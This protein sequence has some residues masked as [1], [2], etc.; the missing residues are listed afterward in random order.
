MT[1]FF[2]FLILM[3]VFINTAFSFA[4]PTDTTRDN[5]IEEYP[6][7]FYIRPIF[8]LRNLT[9][10]LESRSGKTKINYHP[11]GNG[12]LGV[13]AYLFD[14]GIGMSF[15][16]P[17]G[18]KS[19]RRF[20]D[21][22]YLDLQSNIYAKKWG[23]DLSLQLYEGFYVNNP[24]EHFPDWQK[25]DPYPRRSDLTINKVSAN[26]YYI[27][28]HQK[29]SYRSAYNQIERQHAN[30][31]SLFVGT[32]L[33]YQ[34]VSAD[35]SL[36]PYNSRENFDLASFSWANFYS[37]G[38]L[39]GYTHTFIY[40]YLYLNISLAIGP[41]YMI[42]FFKEN[43]EISSNRLITS[44]VNFRTALGYN[45]PKW[46]AGITFINHS[47]NLRTDNLIISGETENIRIFLGYRFKEVGLLK[48]NLL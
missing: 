20:G 16:F 26:L 15:K 5:Y 13:S 35:T 47:S 21:T 28:N 29:F 33:L 6:E 8:T 30:S 14:I 12:Y 32:D 38:V 45:S 44:A 19:S 39:P 37:L 43:N 42:S 7:K 27:E 17:E 4:P 34:E 11:N 48:K 2:S 9:L 25:D 22:E 23:A 46:I 41:A 24:R 1:R 3:A 31:G 10:K 40:K 36:I 18:K